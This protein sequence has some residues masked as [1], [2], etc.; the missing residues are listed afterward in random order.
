MRRQALS[1]LVLA[2]LL[3]C[4]PGAPP[5]DGTATARPT[6]APGTATH[7]AGPPPDRGEDRA[8]TTLTARLPIARYGYSDDE[9][10]AITA[11]EL[12]LARDCARRYGVTYDPPQATA[13]LAPPFADRRYGISSAREAARWG[14]HLPPQPDPASDSGLSAAEQLVL[15]GRRATGETPR[16]ATHRGRRVPAHGCLGEG[17]EKLRNPYEFSAGADAASRIAARSFVRSRQDSRVRAALA[18]WAACMRKNGF[19]Y[20]SPMDPMKNPAFQRSG[21]SRQ[22]KETARSDISCK[23][24]TRLLETWFDAEARV[25]RTAIARDTARLERLRGLHLAK[26]REARRIVAGADR[27]AGTDT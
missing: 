16:D 24:G 5:P 11:A 21:I 10:L 23:R 18:K 20:A 19:S 6:G 3:G 4:S 2:L 27:E 15:Y 25:Q 13:M 7:R 1:A 8:D 14:Y 12:I 17:V 26:V 22:E 9:Y